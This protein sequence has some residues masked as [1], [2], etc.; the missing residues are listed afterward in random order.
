[1]PDVMTDT[2]SDVELTAA[3]DAAADDRPILLSTLPAERSDYGLACAVIVVS[4]F[5]FMALAP[6][7]KTPLAPSPAFMPIYQAA[8]VI[9]DSITFVFLIGQARIAQS[10]AISLLAAGYLFTALMTVAHTLTFPGLFSPTGLLNAGPQTTAWLYMFWHGGFPLFVI[11]Y[12][13]SGG[14]QQTLVTDGRNGRA[15][16][17]A[18]VA[19]CGLALAAT[20]LAT[21]GH[22][23]LF[24]IMDGNRQT[25]NLRYVVWSVWALNLIALAVLLRRKPYSLLD[26]WLIVVMFAW[27]F[28][29]GL[30][31]ALNAGR[32]DLGFYA[33]RIYGFMAASF[34]LIVLLLEHAELYLQYA[35]LRASDRAKAAALQR[36]ST[37]DALTGIANRRAFDEALDEEWRRMMRHRT[38]LSLLLIDVDYFKRFNDSY[39]HVAGDGCLRAVAQAIGKKARRAGE[40]AARYG[41]EEFAV[42][43]PQTSRDDA[44]RLAELMCKVVREQAVPHQ[45]SE[46]SPFVTISIGVACIANPPETAAT[47]SRD[48]VSVPPPGA[49]ILIE[50]ADQALYRAKTGGRNRVAFAGQTAETAAA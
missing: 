28:D 14:S 48:A 31:A 39:G 20:L 18:A 19:A 42:L 41:G 11:G 21:W 10:K 5:A 25:P 17:L 26:L 8:L 46:V 36:L 12:A 16:V 7:A 33:G 29:I 32:F 6:F 38:A 1:M 9:N 47:L 45:A 3:V 49:T 2:I 37:V 44:V 30:S 22:N 34:V 40:L 13:L 35:K 27:L 4:S 50:A 43:L 15:A 24:E 23:G